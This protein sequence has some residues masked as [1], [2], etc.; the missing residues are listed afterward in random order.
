MKIPQEDT[1][2][3]C[4]NEIQAI[5]TGSKYLRMPTIDDTSTDVCL[6]QVSLEG[7]EMTCLVTY[8]M[9]GDAEIFVD[10]KTGIMYELMKVFPEDPDAGLPNLATEAEKRELDN[11]LKLAS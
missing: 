7:Y 5:T 9:E 2:Y 6:R 1:L 8:N 4:A 11:L 10:L 3:I